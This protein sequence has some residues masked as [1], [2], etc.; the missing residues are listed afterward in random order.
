MALWAALWPWRF[1]VD[2]T[3]GK[4]AEQ[5]GQVRDTVLGNRGMWLHH[6]GPEHT[7]NQ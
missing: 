4:A 5:A 2:G 6:S 7:E 3:V 1:Q